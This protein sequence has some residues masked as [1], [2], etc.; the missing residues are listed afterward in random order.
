MRIF[1]YCL[2]AGILGV[3][4]FFT[5]EIVTYVLL[6]FILIALNNVLSVLKEISRKL[7]EKS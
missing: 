2:Y 1:L 4:S 3:I 5:Q 7:D 6:G